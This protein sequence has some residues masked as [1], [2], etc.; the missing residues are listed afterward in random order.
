MMTY[1]KIILAYGD[2]ALAEDTGL[3]GP[4]VSMMKSRGKISSEHW[5]KLIE[6]SK[7]R[8]LVDP[9]SGETFLLTKDLLAE[10]EIHYQKARHQPELDFAGAAQ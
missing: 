6:K 3:K 8:H 5:E 10:A 9:D 2:D 4:A 7:R 1:R